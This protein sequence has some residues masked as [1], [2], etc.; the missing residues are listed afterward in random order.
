[1]GHIL[2]HV[3]DTGIGIS[4][5][6]LE[7]I[8]NLFEQEYEGYT[9]KFEGNGLGLAL[10]REYCKLNNADISVVSKKDEG[11]TFTVKFSKSNK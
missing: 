10:T 11:S 4:E 8:F 9:R 6:N 2:V 7:R 3:K 1:D 5:E